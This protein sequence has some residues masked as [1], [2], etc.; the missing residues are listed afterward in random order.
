MNSGQALDKIVEMITASS[1]Q[2][3]AIAAAA[4]QQSASSESINSIFD[5][6]A[7]ISAQTAEAMERSSTA[8]SN[9]IE[10]EKTLSSLVLRLK[11]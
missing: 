8:V 11:A 7:T 1:D 2:I 4:E 5:D 6:V 9:L 3:Q 10:Q